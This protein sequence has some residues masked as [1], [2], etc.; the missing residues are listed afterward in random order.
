MAA[1]QIV[2]AEAEALLAALRE[3]LGPGVDVGPLA[4]VD[5]LERWADSGAM[6]LT[7]RASEAPLAPSAPVASRIDAAG[8]VLRS[9]T[10]ELASPVEID[11][12]ALLGERAAILGLRRSGE[13]APGGRCRL[14]PAADGWIA[15][16]LARPE[17]LELVPAWLGIDPPAP[18][19]WSA[20]AGAIAERD[21]DDVV[22]RAQLLGL[23]VSGTPS[24]G[25]DVQLDAR[26]TLDATTP[27]IARRLGERRRLRHRPLVVDLSSLWAGP[28]CANLLGLAGARVVKVESTTRKDG[29]RAHPRFFDLLHAGHDLVTLDL[30]ST[31]GVDRLHGLVNEADI[32]IEASRPRA[33]D[34]LGLQPEE[35][36]AS[37]PG[38]TW[39]TITGYG[40]TGPWANR[41][42]FGDD[43]AVA[44]GL[45]VRDDRGPLFCAD[46]VADPA[47]GLLAAVAGA[48]SLVHGGGVHIDLALREVARHLVREPAPPSATAGELVV[49]APRSRSPEPGTGARPSAGTLP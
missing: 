4:E 11:A 48:A 39:I 42:A 33:L 9:L 18:P 16:N 13:I 20:V 47:T 12:P 15:V 27:F 34:H 1:P 35:V 7:G 3:A 49:R 41:V 17:D 37:S 45:L 6:A 30:R 21:A 32:I 19:G 36:L 43:A 2:H 29:A 14:L 24:E 25:A 31:E 38:R 23:A 44:G 5:P 26:G 28:L 10:E 8:Q 40:R 46:A 22:E